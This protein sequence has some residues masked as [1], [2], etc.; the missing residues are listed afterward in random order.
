MYYLATKLGDRVPLS[1]RRCSMGILNDLIRRAKETDLKLTL[2]ELY[3][4]ITDE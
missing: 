1:L 3:K 2:S 4:R